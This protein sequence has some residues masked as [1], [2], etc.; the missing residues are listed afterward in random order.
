MLWIACASS[1]CCIHSFFF[2][3]FFP[4]SSSF[5]CC[6]PRSGAWICFTRAHTTVQLCTHIS[7]NTVIAC[8]GY[9]DG[10]DDGDDGDEEEEAEEGR[11]LCRG[12]MMSMR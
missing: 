10:E 11:E 6:L 8:C 5:G 3:S 4:S 7:I 2:F 12:R 9:D 1:H